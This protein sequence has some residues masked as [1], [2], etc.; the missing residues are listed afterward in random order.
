[1]DDKFIEMRQKYKPEKVKCLF[2]AESPPSRI[3]DKE[4]RFFYNPNSLKWD[5]LFN[6]LMEVIY[7][8]TKRSLDKAT[9]LDRF[10]S[11]G[12]YLIDVVDFPINDLS[13]GDRK[14]IILR[15]LPNKIKE[16][17]ELI[18]FSI[19]VFLIKRLVHDLYYDALTKEGFS[20]RN[21]IF[22]PFPSTGNQKRFKEQLRSYMPVIK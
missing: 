15:E 8:D 22:L 20:V 3:D 18:D 4:I 9:L 17:H 14:A 16:T 10:K 12:F 11:D 21:R 19:P 5:F 7:P 13:D 2:I 1:M 6:S